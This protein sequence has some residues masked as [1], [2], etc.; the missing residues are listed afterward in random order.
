MLRKAEDY[1][2]EARQ[3]WSA[4]RIEARRDEIYDYAV[5]EDDYE[6]EDDL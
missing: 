2:D 5:D 6:D 4:A 1:E 3:A